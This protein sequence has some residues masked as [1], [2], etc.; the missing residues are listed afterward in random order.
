M[1][2]RTWP[3]PLSGGGVSHELALAFTKDRG[4]NVLMIPPLFDEHNKLRAQ[5]VAVMRCLDRAGFDSVLADLPGC[6]ESLVPLEDVTLSGWRAAIHAAAELLGCTHVLA[7]R[8]GALLAPPELPGWQYAPLTGAKQL[9]AMLRA[10]TIAAR[11]AGKAEVMADLEK[12]ARTDGIALAGWQLSAELF[13]GLEAAEPQTGTFQHIITQAEIGGPALWLRAEP[14]R[15]D[16]QADA[17]AELV[18]GQIG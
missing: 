5:I 8:A 16:E 2:T 12:I 10:R 18:V 3:C 4:A 17:L 15:D 7:W 13:T 14:E 1:L 11:E 9:R 6:N